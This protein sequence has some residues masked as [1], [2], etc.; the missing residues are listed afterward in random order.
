MARCTDAA[1]TYLARY[2]YNVVR[3]PDPDITP[4]EVVGVRGGNPERIGLIDKV[5]KDTT[6]AL[7]EVP[8]PAPA[9]D[10]RGVSSS[11]MNV[12]LGVK[13]LATF[14]APM[15]GKV[16]ATIDFTNA[17]RLQFSFEDVTRRRVA[18]AAVGSFLLGAD[19]NESHPTVRPYLLGRAR[20]FVITETLHASSLTVR[21]ERT[22]GEAAK[23]E[24]AQIRDLLGGEIV[25]RAVG[26]ESHVLTYTR[27]AALVFGF[28]C[29]ELGFLDGDLVMVAVAPGAVALAEALGPNGMAPDDMAS[30]LADQYFPLVDFGGY[31]HDDGR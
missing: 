2:G 24:V 7:P 29:Y 21:F 23:V 30:L 15:G 12:R 9:P 20:L 25:V 1:T 14:L 11:S 31:E 3:Y 26:D 19:F 27:T 13:L 6:S 8:H 5:V 4:L 22:R 28:K 10:L 18:P 17:R 16:G